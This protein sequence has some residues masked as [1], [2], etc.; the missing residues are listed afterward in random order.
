MKNFKF[1]AIPFCISIALS[2]NAFAL[3]VNKPLRCPSVDAIKAAGLRMV[4]RDDRNG[5]Y[6]AVQVGNFD[7]N[8]KWAFGLLVPMSDADSPQDALVKAREA[9]PELSGEAEQGTYGGKTVCQYD[10]LPN[11]YMAIAFTPIM[12]G[13]L[14]DMA[15]YR[16][17]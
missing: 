3:S 17:R 8:V 2:A 1:A 12:M 10:P 13:Q 5:F 4:E 16:V 15:S 9:L 11:G 7:T 6:V 14:S